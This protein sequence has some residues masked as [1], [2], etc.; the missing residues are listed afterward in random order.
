MTTH[1]SMNEFS[2]PCVIG[3]HYPCLDGIFAAL[4]AREKLRTS[5]TVRSFV[6]LNTT[7]PPAVTS[8]G[9]KGHETVFLLDFASPRSFVEAVAKRC[10][11]LVVIDHHITAWE[12]LKAP[13]LPPNVRLYFN[14]DKCAASLALEFFRPLNISHKI[15][16]I[17][18]SDIRDGTLWSC[19]V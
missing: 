18:E 2:G 6:P 1:N 5:H 9:L 8:L 4:I 3:Y 16:Q 7:N 15:H 19:A 17:V 12:A 13:P 10:R 11:Q 14:L